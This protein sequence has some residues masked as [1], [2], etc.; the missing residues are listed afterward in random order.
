MIVADVEKE[1]HMLTTLFKVTLG[2]GSVGVVLV[3]GAIL[4]LA[5]WI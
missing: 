5:H 1:L 4:R 3:A 2:V